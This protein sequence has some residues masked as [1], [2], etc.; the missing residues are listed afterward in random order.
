MWPDGAK[1]AQEIASLVASGKVSAREM[2]DTAVELLEVHDDQLNV[3]AT[4]M[5][6]RAR[7]AAQRADDNL[8]R[9]GAVGPLHGVPFGVKDL[10]DIEGV[11]TGLGSPITSGTIA[12]ETATSVAR[13]EQAGAI[14]VAKLK[15]TEFA[16]VA[17]H[18]AFPAP[19]NPHA[20]DHHPGGS[21]SGSGVAVAAGLLPFALGSDTVAS[22]RIPAAWNGCT[23]F[24]PSFGRTSR[25]GVFPLAAT[26]DHGGPLTRSADDAAF[27]TVAMAGRDLAD[28]TTRRD[29]LE[30]ADP[31]AMGLDGVRVGYDESFVKSMSAPVVAGC[32]DEAVRA[33]EQADAQIVPISIPMRAP[34]VDHYFTLFC[35]QVAYAH[36]S[37]FPLRR[38]DY[39][40]SFA[41]LLDLASQVEVDQLVAATEF[42]VGFAQA[43]EALFEQVDVIVMPVAPVNAPAGGP[44]PDD[45]PLD[46][47]TISRLQFT[48]L[49]NLCGAPAIA[50]PWG[51]DAEG[52]PN[53]VQVI[54]KPGD[55]ATALSLAAKIEELA[56]RL[57]PPRTS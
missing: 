49:W 5:F 48:W 4:E 43:I 3:V 24:K 56:P 13:L 7:A 19:V 33:A 34:A 45:T 23:G 40:P 15:M 6:D 12:T 46:L 16:G 35:A 50:L 2:V 11:N 22:I 10:F 29:R 54:T 30:L 25:H 38:D 55:D 27:I 26:F 53:S 44:G 1:S 18:G 21:S 31:P 32:S 37:F 42:R 47:G 39:T 8:A 41:S 20:P 57:P 36:R 28:P 14:P 52:L 17:H 51:L 9:A